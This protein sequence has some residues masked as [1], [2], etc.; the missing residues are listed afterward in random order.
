MQPKQNAL[1]KCLSHTL[2]YHSWIWVIQKLPVQAVSAPSTSK[3]PT[4][5]GGT[6]SRTV[7]VEHHWQADSI[8]FWM[9][10]ISHHPP[11]GGWLRSA[12][13]N[14]CFNLWRLWFKKCFTSPSERGALGKYFV[15]LLGYFFWMTVAF[16]VPTASSRKTDCEVW[17]VFSLCSCKWTNKILG[18]VF[19]FLDLWVLC[20]SR[21][22]D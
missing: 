10:F 17:L 14:T 19:V 4:A 1:L 15:Y 18:D 9:G 7:P 11:Q 3:P 16:R 8:L 22:S 20:Q 5:G 6:G 21:K 2:T 12:V 13:S